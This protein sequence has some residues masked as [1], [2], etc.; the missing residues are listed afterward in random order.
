MY[1][2][3]QPIGRIRYTK[4]RSPCLRLWT[5]TVNIPSPPF[6]LNGRNRWSV[7]DVTP[8]ARGFGSILTERSVTSELGGKVEHD[9]RRK[10]LRLK[11][12]IP[13]ATDPDSGIFTASMA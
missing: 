12:S 6:I 11:L 1:E 7:I 3:G 9:W 4:E 8:W 2:D 5:V 13:P 10:G